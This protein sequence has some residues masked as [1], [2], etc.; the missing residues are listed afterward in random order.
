MHMLRGIFSTKGVLSLE[1]KPPYS[2]GGLLL[3]RLEAV[4]QEAE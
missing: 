4:E 2:V 3:H 1:F